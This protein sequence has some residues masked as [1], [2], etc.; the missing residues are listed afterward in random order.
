M[1]SCFVSRPVASSS[2][3]RAINGARSGS[4]TRLLPD[5]FG[6]FRY[7]MGAG[8]VHRPS[9]SAARIPARVRSERTSL[10]NCAKDASTPSISLPVDVSSIGSVADRSEMPRDFR[11]ARSAKWSYFSR[12]NR[13][14]LPDGLVEWLV[15]NV[16]ETPSPDGTWLDRSGES[17]I[18]QAGDEVAAVLATRCAGERAVLPFQ[19][20]P[21]VDHD[22][23][24]ELTLPLREADDIPEPHHPADADAVER[25]VVRVLVRHRNSSMTRGCGAER[26]PPPRDPTT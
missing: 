24:E 13:V 10:S 1:T 11:C 15:V 18:D 23:H 4:A 14:R 22:R 7:P 5:H 3:A 2:N 9:S 6:A 21:G 12:A 8:K 25:R 19:E 16:V 20:A 26:P 17:A